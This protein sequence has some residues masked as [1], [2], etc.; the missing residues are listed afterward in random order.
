MLASF[1]HTQQFSLANPSKYS[2][3]KV[4]P[5]I[6]THHSLRPREKQIKKWKASGDAETHLQVS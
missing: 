6:T 4:L 2:L 5:C 1:S 3:P